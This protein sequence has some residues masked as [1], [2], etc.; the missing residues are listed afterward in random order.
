MDYQQRQALLQ[1]VKIA[2]ISV[3]CGG[4]AWWIVLAAALGW[5]SPTTAAQQTSDAVQAKVDQVLAPFCAHR[6]M[7][8]KA[9]LAKFVKAG[10]DYSRDEIVQKAVPMLGATKITYEMSDKCATAIEAK[11][12][13]A[14]R[15]A[16][17]KAP[18]KS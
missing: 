6:V 12:K 18:A 10:G 4:V 5:V 11:L 16:P 7:A 1:K 15:K 8:D 9:V 2:G 14:A 3:V 13:S 17:S